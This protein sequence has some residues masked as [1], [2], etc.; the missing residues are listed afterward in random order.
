MIKTLLIIIVVSIGCSI[1]NSGYSRAAAKGTVF[2]YRTPESQ[3][4]SRYQYDT[5]LLQ[6][7][8][9]STVETDGAYRLVPSPVMNFARARSFIKSNSLPNFIL[10]LSYEPDFENNNMAYVPFPVDLGIVGYRVCF[11]HPEVVEQLS[12]VDSLDKLRSF[13]HGQGTGWTDIGILRHNGFDV[14]EVANY[15][16]LFKMV[17]TR[18][19]DLFCRGANELLDEFKA[20]EHIQNLSYDKAIAFFYP[21]PRFFYTNAANTEALDRISRGLAIAY[22][23]G[24]LQKLWTRRYKESVDFVGLDQRRIFTLENPLIESLSVDY[25]RYFLNPLEL[26]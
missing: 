6:L 7:A 13:T 15:E 5:Q 19:F 4:D 21:F 18:R 14:T 9:E 17:S 22:N 24:S 26:K 25:Q 16:S 2:T 12:H 3:T 1:Q 11:A 8:L 20:H 23:N 10:K